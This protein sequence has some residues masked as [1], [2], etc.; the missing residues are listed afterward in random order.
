[1]SSTKR[2]AL[3][4]LFAGSLLCAP[5]V[6]AGLSQEF[7]ATDH[8]A[9]EYIYELYASGAWGRWP[10]GTRPWAR[11]DIAE[12]VRDI[13]RRDSTEHHLKPAERRLLS[14]LLLEFGDDLRR[15]A[16]EGAMET[17][18][19]GELFG[20]ASFDRAALP[21]YRG[22]AQGFFGLGTDRWW[23]RLRGD[24]DSHGELDPTFF[25][26]PWQD[27]LT[28]TVDVA[29]F[30]LRT[31]GFELEVGR[32]FI[33]WGSAPH[34]VLLLNDQSPPFDMARFVYHHRWFDFSFFFTGLDSAF[35]NPADDSADVAL[36]V[37]RYLSGHRLE[38]RPASSLEIGLSEVVVWG[39][40]ERQLE[41]YYLNPFLPYYWEQL[42]VDSDDNPLWSLDVSWRIPRGPM[43]YGELLIDDFQIDFESEPQQVGW[44]LGFNWLDVPLVPGSF[45][46]ADWTHIEPTV[47]GQNRPYNRYLNFHVG[48]G[49]DLGPDAE[50]YLL[51]WRQHLSPALDLTLRGLLQRKGEREIDTPQDVAVTRDQFPT[52][53]VE[54]TTETE[55]G[56]YYQP[57]RRLRFDLRAGYRWLENPDHVEG[58]R[59]DGG[60]VS[61]SV[62]ITDWLTGSF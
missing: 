36:N 25:G 27:K 6:Q 51:R 33:R 1:V 4:A 54:T 35:S 8:W 19:G 9:N 57:S 52:G 24:I 60:F 21:I 62:A 34:D 18:P 61:A 53:V 44:Q 56:V 40:P 38:V 5:S 29:Y 58:S 16:A 37:K 22:R 13:A 7:L 11:G 26:E 46:T 15:S 45:V 10:I 39:G 55:L 12:R 20:S 43:A 42:N 14:R 48:M 17:R 47:Y 3:A 28:G 41:A 32:D 30:T 50:R 49:S 23:V 2:Y 59:Q 31:G